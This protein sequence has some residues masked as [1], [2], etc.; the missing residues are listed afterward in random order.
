MGTSTLAPGALPTQINLTVNCSTVILYRK[1]KKSQKNHKIQKSKKTNKRRKRIDRKNL[2][3]Y[4]QTPNI[5]GCRPH[6]NCCCPVACPVNNKQSSFTINLS[7]ESLQLLLEPD[8]GVKHPPPP[9]C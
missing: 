7:G 6:D 8:T 5:S 1:N 3:D 4:L 9:E 2:V